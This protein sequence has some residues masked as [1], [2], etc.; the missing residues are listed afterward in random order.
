VRKLNVVDLDGTLIHFDSFRKLVLMQLNHTILWIL[1]RRALRFIGR[2]QAAFELHQSLAPVLNDAE[3]VRGFCQELTT[4]MEPE[5]VHTV[6][7]NTDPE[8]VNLLLSASPEEYVRVLAEMMDF[9]GVGSSLTTSGYRHMYGEAKKAFVLA[10]YPQSE[11]EYNIA[12]S[13][14]SSDAPLLALFR[15]QVWV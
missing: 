1:L 15:Q 6:S 12:V 11:F 2:Q 10:T 7:E 3:F 13:D 4:Q 14:S 9:S 8:T 5:V